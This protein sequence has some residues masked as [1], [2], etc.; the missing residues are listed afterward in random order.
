MRFKSLIMLALAAGM[1]PSTVRARLAASEFTVVVKLIPASGG[2]TIFVHTRIGATC[3]GLA[4]VFYADKGMTSLQEQHVRGTGIVTWSFP[5]TSAPFGVAVQITCTWM[6]PDGYEQERSKSLTTPPAK[7]IQAKMNKF[8]E[9]LRLWEPGID[10]RATVSV[11]SLKPKYYYGHKVEWECGIEG[12]IGRDPAIPKNSLMTCAT[13]YGEYVVS[14]P[15][16][17]HVLRDRDH[18]SAWIFGTV[19]TPSRVAN[20]T[21]DAVPE[22]KILAAFVEDQRTGMPE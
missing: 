9:D 20:K 16:K 2:Y 6:G 12:F 1:L 17:I 5:V 22:P 8:N 18:V 4:G 15:P 7:S 11:V 21:G 13:A 10:P 3:G 14:T 19:S